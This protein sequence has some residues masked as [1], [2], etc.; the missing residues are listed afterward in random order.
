MKNKAIII[1]CCLL[2]IR[3][4]NAQ[5]NEVKIASNIIYV[6]VLGICGYGSINYEKILNNDR[7][8]KYG[9]KAGISTYHFKDYTNSFNPDILIPLGIDLI[10]GNKHNL[11]VGLG[12]VLSSIVHANSIDF[13][14]YRK[15]K[16]SGNLSI[17]YRFQKQTQGIF[18]KF[19]YTPLFE[20]Y[21][22]FRHWGGISFGYIF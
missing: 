15:T 1:L 9:F 16:L 20:Y 21:K 2:V 12:Q 7:T 14:P 10:I 6:E 5:D 19:S 22:R 4:L 11:E 17:G 18:F 13:Q 8:I 3:N